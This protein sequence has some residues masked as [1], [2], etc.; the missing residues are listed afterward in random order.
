MPRRAA[1]CSTTRV[2]FPKADG[3]PQAVTKN[4]VSPANNPSVTNEMLIAAPLSLCF[5]L[6]RG[7]PERWAHN[8]NQPGTH[9]KHTKPIYSSWD[10]HF[11]STLGQL[12]GPICDYVLGLIVDGHGTDTSPLQYD[13]IALPPRP[14]FLRLARNLYGSYPENEQAAALR[15]LVMKGE[16]LGFTLEDI[17]AVLTISNLGHFE[18]WCFGTVFSARLITSSST[19]SY[20]GGSR[21]SRCWTRSC[22]LVWRRGSDCRSRMMMMMMGYST[23]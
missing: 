12:F 3:K 13:G 7:I 10:I 4:K 17:K 19:G 23:G 11:I 1:T 16:S 22:G 8:C 2:S 15:Y 9:E 21:I 6:E 14:K 5:P 20:V 18:A